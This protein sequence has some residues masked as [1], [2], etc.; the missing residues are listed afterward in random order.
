MAHFTDLKLYWEEWGG[1]PERRYPFGEPTLTWILATRD[2]A[3]RCLIRAESKGAM[4]VSWT[5]SWAKL[6]SHLIEPLPAL[7]E[8]IG[9]FDSQKPLVAD[10]PDGA[11]LTVWDLTG[12]LLDRPFHLSLKFT[13]PGERWTPLGQRL[14]TALIALREERGKD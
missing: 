3:A 11:Y 12:V 14:R 2:S 4:D 5:A 7:L 8:D 13:R 10:A 1:Y 6:P 9:A